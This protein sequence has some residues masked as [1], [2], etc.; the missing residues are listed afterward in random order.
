VL[1]V[2]LSSVP[3]IH[4]ERRSNNDS[5]FI[6]GSVTAYNDHHHLNLR[7]E[8]VWLSILVQLK[9]YINAHAEEVRHLFVDR[10]DQQELIICGSTEVKGTGHFG[11]DWGL[12]SYKMSSFL[13]ENVKDP[14][15][16]DWILP[17]FTTTTK[18]DQAVASILMLASLQKYFEYGYSTMCGFPSIT[19]L[20]QKEDWVN[21]EEKLERL[22]SFGDEV[23]EWYKLLKPV[24]GRFVGTFEDPES[25]ET[26]EFWTKFAHYWSNGSGNNYLSGQFAGYL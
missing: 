12:F 9:C 8:D 2:L 7:P 24:L 6:N 23:G 4:G 16:R 26:K 5:G 22:P 14:S 17:A 25:E 20:G 18:V 21:L 10:T 11:V 1:G 15:L 3:S 13:S 19:L